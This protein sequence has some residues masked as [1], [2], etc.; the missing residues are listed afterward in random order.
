MKS[1]DASG[2]NSNIDA[3]R[4]AEATLRLIAN[5]PAPRD[6]ENRVIAGLRSTPASAR[7]LNWLP[8]PADNWLRAA[9]A[10]AI[11]FLVVGGGWG[12]YSRVQ[13]EGAT[14]TIPQPSRSTG[15]SNAGA[16]R[17]PQTLQAPTVNEPAL[18]QPAPTKHSKAPLKAE[19][20]SGAKAQ[21]SNKGAKPQDK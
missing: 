8:N 3:V 9:A 20:K 2:S 13:P 15:F 14:A 6:L 4:D 19:P 21:S 10:A 7:V 11:A 18:V 16:V 17:V 5:L 1:L 12:I